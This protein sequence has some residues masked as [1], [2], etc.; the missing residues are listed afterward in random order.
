MKLRL[1][2]TERKDGHRA[3]L[4][5]RSVAHP[6]STMT[7]YEEHLELLAELNQEKT[8]PERANYFLEE[9]YA[10]ND[11]DRRQMLESDLFKEFGIVIE[12]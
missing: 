3:G 9:Y 12:P 6:K 7:S 11:S 10:T 5:A 1:I 4:A 8:Y 2:R